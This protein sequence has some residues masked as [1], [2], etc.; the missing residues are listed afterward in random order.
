MHF[1][2]PVRDECDNPTELEG[3][4][5]VDGTWI[6]PLRPR[7]RSG[8]PR[9]AHKSRVSVQLFAVPDTRIERLR[10]PLILTE[11]RVWRLEH[12]FGRHRAACPQSGRLKRRARAYRENVGPSGRRDSHPQCQIVGHERVPGN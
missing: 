1:A 12:I 6:D 10:L 3:K 8:S 4:W 11:A 5:G 9:F 2:G 7:F